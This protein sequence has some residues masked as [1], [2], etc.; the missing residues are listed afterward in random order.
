MFGRKKDTTP[1]PEPTPYSY[2]EEER[3]IQAG[4]F[5]GWLIHIADRSVQ[6][7]DVLSYRDIATIAYNA[8]LIAIRNEKDGTAEMK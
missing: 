2:S 3:L 5:F 7:Y 4:D 8:A 6:G 1:T